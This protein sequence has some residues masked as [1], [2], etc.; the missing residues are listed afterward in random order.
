[1]T[2]IALVVALACPSAASGASSNDQPTL[3][4]AVVKR[5]NTI[6]TNRGLSRLRVIPRLAAAA[7]SHTTVM[8]VHGY[9]DHDWWDGTPM[10]TWIRWFYPGPGY[11][12]WAAAENL[13]WSS[14]HPTA[15]RV[16]RWWMNSPTH[17][18]NILGRWRHIGASAIRVR[19]PT[20]A[21]RRYSAV[22]IVAVEFGRRS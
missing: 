1:M 4:A 8:A 6:R 5:I 22:T 9:C 21:F 3:E 14:W 18:A 7:T 20:G 2:S 12:S 16:V 15:R 13:Y 10:S 11:S 17:R 19:N